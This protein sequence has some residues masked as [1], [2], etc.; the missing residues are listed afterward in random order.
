MRPT[1]LY[2]GLR[3][4]CHSDLVTSASH[5]RCERRNERYLASSGQARRCADHVLF[6]NE[7]FKKTCGVRLRKFFGERGI[8]CIAVERNDAGILFRDFHQSV[9]VSFAC[10]RGFTG[11]ARDC[12]IELS[13]EP[14]Y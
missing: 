3:N 2:V 8:L 11:L 10:R 5:E 9:T 1:E 14:G 7:H 6:S 12:D 13:L 4:A